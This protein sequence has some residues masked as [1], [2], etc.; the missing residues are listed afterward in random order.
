MAPR[1]TSLRAVGQVY[2]NYRRKSTSGWNVWNV[3]LDFQGGFLS[4][5]QHLMD[6]GISGARLHRT[7]RVHHVVVWVTLSVV[8][9]SVC[10]L[11]CRL[12]VRKQATGAA[13]AAILSSSAWAS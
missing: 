11:C 4:V 9:V 3:I 12:F 5:V 7:P 10:L 8:C 6:S 13:L 1:S 2:V